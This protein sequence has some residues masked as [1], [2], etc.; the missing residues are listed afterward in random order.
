MTEMAIIGIDRNL[1]TGVFSKHNRILELSIG[2]V[3]K[4][5]N[6]ILIIYSIF[7]LRIF[8]E[9]NQMRI[10]NRFTAFMAERSI[11]NV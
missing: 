8:Y 1:T 6:I 3:F 11:S 9:N 5:R 7:I 10:S 2:H 4:K